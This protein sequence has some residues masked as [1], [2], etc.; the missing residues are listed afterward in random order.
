MKNTIINLICGLSLLLISA[1]ASIEVDTAATDFDENKYVQDL[2]DCRGG[3]LAESS[4]KSVG[5]GIV[6]GLAGATQGLIQGAIRGYTAESVLV[7]ASFGAVIGLGAGA[8]DSYD[9]SKQELRECMMD[10]GYTLF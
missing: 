9:E 10:K 1:C 6:G 2:S 3:N 8:Y 7:W 4:V 5:Y